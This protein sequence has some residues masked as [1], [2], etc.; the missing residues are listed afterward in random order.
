M[1]EFY[2]YS[3]L[4]NLNSILVVTNATSATNDLETSKVTEEPDMGDKVGPFVGNSDQGINTV[5]EEEVLLFDHGGDFFYQ[6]R[7]SF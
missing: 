7:R 2:L 1:L 5:E 6:S 3:N 4:E